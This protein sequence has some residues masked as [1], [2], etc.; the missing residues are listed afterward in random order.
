MEMPDFKDK[1]ILVAG[2]IMLDKY[3]SGEVERISPEAPVQVVNVNKEKYLLGGA[4]NVCNNIAALGC[5][6][7]IAGA[8]GND[9][10]GEKIMQI[11]KEK[12]IDTKLV[13]KN[14][15][16]TTQKVR[17]VSQGQQLLRIDYETI[18]K[19]PAKI[20][21]EGFDIIIISDYAKGYVTK[22]SVQKMIQTGKK[23]IIDPK[24]KNKEQYKGAYLI[25]PNLKEAKEMSKETEINKIGKKLTEEMNANILITAGAE[26]MYL[27]EKGKEMKHLPTK[28]KEVYD[29]T[30]A[31]DTV[32]ATLAATTAG[33][34]ELQEAADI[35]NHAAGI[36][37]GKRGTATTTIEEIKKSMEQKIEDL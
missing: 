22:E 34:A 13:E 37:V 19:T 25:T 23:V 16:Q 1:K 32:I 7:A 27:F 14:K 28:A 6:T 30:G 36:V 31:G 35:A 12:N 33:G 21:D 2:D 11:L 20:E 8:I 15:K 4:G 5:K 10:A 29:V 9:Q 17:I 3:I 24:P 26:G 18:E